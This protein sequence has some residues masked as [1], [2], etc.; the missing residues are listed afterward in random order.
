MSALLMEEMSTN[1]LVNLHIEQAVLDCVFD[2]SAVLYFGQSVFCLSV[3][4]AKWF[5]DQKDYI[6]GFLCVVKTSDGVSIK[7]KRLK[8]PFKW[9]VWYSQFHPIEF[10]FKCK[11]ISSIL[12]LQRNCHHHAKIMAKWWFQIFLAKIV[13]YVK[14]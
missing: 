5:S 3:E 12:V 7:I 8:W 9:H 13:P 14:P 2:Q 10:C 4:V 11:R 1:F 6:L